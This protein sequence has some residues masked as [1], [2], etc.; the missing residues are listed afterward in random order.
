LP[1][2]PTNPPIKVPVNPTNPPIKPPTVAPIVKP[3]D[4][5]IVNPTNPPITIPTVPPTIYQCKDSTLKFRYTFDDETEINK[6]CIWVGDFPNNDG[7][8]QN[9]RCNIPGVK[10]HCNLSC[11]NCVCNDSPLK[12]KVFDEKDNKFRLRSCDQV[13][14]KLN[15][16]DRDGVSSTCPKTCQMCTAPPTSPTTAPVSVSTSVPIR[17]PTTAPVSVPTS[18]PTRSPTD[19]PAS[20][21]PTVSPTASPTKAPVHPTSPPCSIDWTWRFEGQ[22]TK[23]CGWVERK[24]MCWLKGAAEACCCEP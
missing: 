1:V 23:G 6:K 22:G 4:A 24:D 14:G 17:S 13:K 12:F 10:D 8:E 15:L 3:T 5:P 18:A 16:C 21:A 19:H 7:F 20:L 9:E 2:N 11:N